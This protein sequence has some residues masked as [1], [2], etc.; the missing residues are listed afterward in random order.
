V[1]PAGWAF[2]I[3][4]IIYTLLGVF[5][6]YQA[7]PKEKVPKRNDELIFGK[8]G[9]WLSYNQVLN[10][11]WLLIF[12]FDNKWAFAIS[13]VDIL[14]LLGTCIHIV[15]L[16]VRDHI[17]NTWEL[18]SLRYGFSIYAG[19][20]TAATILNLGFAAKSWG[21]SGDWESKA[22][23]V[24]LWA[25][26]GIYVLFSYSERNPMYGLIYIWVLLGIYSAQKSHHADIVQTCSILF[27]LHSC[28]IV[29]ITGLSLFKKNEKKHG[30]CTHGLF[31]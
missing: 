12:G 15:K 21:I 8:I 5:T 20:V 11:V 4:G 6:V 9:Y 23:C 18:V 7:L 25:A 30:R 10:S 27:T 24:V 26:F 17:P 22:T 16:T 28:L 19:W 1:T 13:L 14:L 31:Y 3:W 29:A 2:A